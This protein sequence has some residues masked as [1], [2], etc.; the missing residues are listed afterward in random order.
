MTYLNQKRIRGVN[1]IVM[2]K[3]GEKHGFGREN[4]AKKFAKENIAEFAALYCWEFDGFF[5]AKPAYYKFEL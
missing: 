5:Y 4:D 2:L 1:H 3:N